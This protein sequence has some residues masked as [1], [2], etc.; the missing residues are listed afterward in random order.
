MQ[1]FPLKLQHQNEFNDS[2]KNKGVEAYEFH[3][4]SNSNVQF[5]LWA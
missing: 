1:V 2:F 4:T 3:R 5:T